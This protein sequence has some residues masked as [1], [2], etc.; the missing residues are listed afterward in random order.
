ML[1][2]MD[3]I[4]FAHPR[5]QLASDSIPQRNYQQLVYGVLG[6]AKFGCRGHPHGQGIALRGIGDR[7]FPH[8]L[9]SCIRK[10]PSL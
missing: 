3:E 2:W 9:F 10:G 4:H 1:L 7:W 8:G 5:N 6:G